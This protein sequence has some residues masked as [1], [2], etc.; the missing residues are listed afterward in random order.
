MLA[1]TINSEELSDFQ[2]DPKVCAFK[3][4]FGLSWRVPELGEVAQLLA[5]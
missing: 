3:E 4:N 5:L 2:V 1:E